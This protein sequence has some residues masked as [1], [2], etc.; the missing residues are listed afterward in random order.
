[1]DVNDVLHG[2]AAM[3]P[4]TV[5]GGVP[6]ELRCRYIFKYYN[7]SQTGFLNLDEL[8]Y[9]NSFLIFCSILS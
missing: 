6:A 1:M 8:K 7:V 2:M 3:D 9:E 5:H 4:R